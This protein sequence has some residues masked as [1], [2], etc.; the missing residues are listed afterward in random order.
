MLER[1][2]IMNFALLEELEISFCEHLNVLTGET[3]AGKSIVID[4]VSVLLGG[5]A[6][7]EYIRTG[8]SKAIL[9][10]AFYLPPGHR[11][12][13][14]IKD[15]GIEGEDDQTLLLSREIAV[16]GRNTCR[17]NG[18]TLPLGLYRLV[19][20]AIV[21]IHGQHD[22][23][24]LLQAEN[25]INILDQFGGTEHLDMVRIVKDSYNQWSSAKKELEELRAAG[26]ERLQRLDFLNYQITEIRET[27]LKPGEM[28]DLMREA[29]V[30][31]N[32]EKISSRL[33]E[34]YRFLFGG[35]RGMSAYE[36]VSQALAGIADMQKIDPDLEKIRC[37]LEPCLYEIEEAAGALRNYLERID[38]SPQRLEQVE[39]RLQTIRDIYKKYGPTFE[40]VMAYLEKAQI[41]LDRWDKS[42]SRT[43]EL[44]AF[45]DE[46]WRT[47]RDKAQQ[48]SS[49]RK[50]IGETLVKRITC[51]LKELDMPYVRFAVNMQP[52]EAS[53]KGLD[54][55]EFLIAPNPG[56][57]LLP[58]AKIASGG[59]LSRIMLALKKLIAHLDGIGTLIFDEIDAGIGGKA[60]QRVAEKL[61]T[62]SKSQQVVCVTH[63]PSLAALADLHLLLE[64][65]V[66]EGR[67]KTVVRPLTK[68]ER[69]EELSRM[70]GGDRQTIEL[71][72]HA[73][74]I[75]KK[76]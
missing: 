43:E 57:P 76:I 11:A 75:I 35:E 61:E 67:T 62:I 49:R 39:R 25:H 45:V 17:V 10:G 40:E 55:V 8:A 64:K 5:R 38:F 22:H 34:A 36:L 70:L 56:E 24:S 51:E 50:E 74:K 42:A 23:Q 69:V 16:N 52:G 15:M 31:A 58:V 27:R 2:Y 41:E 6:Q 20:L 68:E 37:E 14:M 32:A 71:K 21:D 60:A 3:G 30:L 65:N 13:D 47:Y 9:E 72:K 7:A 44:E 48:V 12:F 59:E 4:A 19:G 73:S 63:S 1:L 26:K 66:I 18:R 46:A 33:H 54:Q 53:V 29:K 28:E